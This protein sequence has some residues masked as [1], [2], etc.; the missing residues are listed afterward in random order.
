MLEILNNKLTKRLIDQAFCVRFSAMTTLHANKRDQAQKLDAVRQEGNIPA[1]FYG[2]GKESTPVSVNLK[3]FTKV[4]DEVGEVHTLTLEVDGSK[5]DTLVHQV[6]RHPVS[7]DVL[8]VDFLVID[9]NKPVEVSVP[10]QFV[11]ISEAEKSG[12]I[13]TKTLHEVEVRALPAKLPEHLEVDQSLLADE[14]S[15]IHLK[16]IKLPEGVEIV[17]DPEKVV[18][19]VT[20]AKEESE[21]SVSAEEAMAN[22]QVEKKGKAEE[23]AGD[24]E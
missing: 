10:L 16:D 7:G 5:V 13:I 19:S 24:S 11:G 22:I 15:V 1:V 23:A 3:E 4:Y 9:T 14:S 8:H 12:G 17:N 20:V 6:D 21:D 18:A 2:A